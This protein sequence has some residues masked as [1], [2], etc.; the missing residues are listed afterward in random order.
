MAQLARGLDALIDRLARHEAGREA[1][2]QTVAADEIEAP[3]PL[4]EPEQA[5][6]H[7][8]VWHPVEG[9]ERGDRRPKND[10]EASRGTERSIEG[11]P[12]RECLCN[13]VT[14]VTLR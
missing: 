2:R 1:P 13:P 9:R 8:H 14:G 7:D 12:S 5:L 11:A 6:S 10:H 4:G 3:L